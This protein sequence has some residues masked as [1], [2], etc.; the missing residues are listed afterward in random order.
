MGGFGGGGLGINRR[1]SGWA[2]VTCDLWGCDGE[3]GLAGGS[4]RERDREGM[5]FIEQ[6]ARR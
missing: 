6:G 4:E 2:R 5:V 1:E 3:A